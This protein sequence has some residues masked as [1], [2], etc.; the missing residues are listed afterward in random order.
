MISNDSAIG[1]GERGNRVASKPFSRIGVEEL[2]VAIAKLKV[3]DS[4]AFFSIFL[5]ILQELDQVFF[6]DSSKIDLWNCKLSF[7]LMGVELKKGLV[8]ILN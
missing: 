6:E 3:S 4:T 7:I 1:Q 8:T 5:L 2:G